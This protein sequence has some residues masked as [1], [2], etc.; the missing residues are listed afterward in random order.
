MAHILH[1]SHSKKTHYNFIF[2]VRSHRQMLH[3]HSGREHAGSQT[4]PQYNPPLSQTESQLCFH[5]VPSAPECE[6]S[7]P[8][9]H[10]SLSLFQEDPGTE[11]TAFKKSIFTS[12]LKSKGHDWFIAKRH[13]LWEQMFLDRR[14]TVKDT[15]WA[16]FHD[17]AGKHQPVRKDCKRNSLVFCK[18]W[19]HCKERIQQHL[20]LQC[21]V[22]LQYWLTVYQCPKKYYTKQINCLIHTSFAESILYSI[23]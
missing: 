11:Y 4:A 3:L 6:H 21:A 7:A 15:V 12:S 16:L 9:L 18:R 14:D 23:T 22:G 10:T 13:L 17:L 8:L 20:K 1:K 19:Q 2:P 5:I